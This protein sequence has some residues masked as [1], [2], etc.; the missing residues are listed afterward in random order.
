MSAKV[1]CDSCGAPGCDPILDLCG[2][3]R[4]MCSRCMDD[5]RLWHLAGGAHRLLKDLGPGVDPSA[6]QQLQDRI[7]RFQL[8]TF[9]NQPLD[10][11]LAHLAREVG[12]TRKDPNDITEWADM[13]ILFLGSAGRN[14]FVTADLIAAAHAKMDINEKRKWKPADVEGVHEH[15]ED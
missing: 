11:Q 12:E 6:V 5:G 4:V 2:C 15:A 7:V 13:F 8:K 9:P 14:F 10:G 1:P 3:Q